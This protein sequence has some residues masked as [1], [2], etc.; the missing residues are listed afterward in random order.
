MEIDQK[1]KNGIVCTT[2]KGQMGSE[3]S[4]KFESVLKEIFE[5]NCFRD[6]FAIADSV[7]SGIQTLH[8][9]FNAA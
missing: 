4:P 5:G 3:L 7:E 8:S 1:E 2:M 6:T 9:T